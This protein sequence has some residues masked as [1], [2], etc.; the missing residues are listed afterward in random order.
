[1]ITQKLEEQH[2]TLKNEQRQLPKSN[3]LADFDAGKKV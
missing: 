3:R 1:V 2:S